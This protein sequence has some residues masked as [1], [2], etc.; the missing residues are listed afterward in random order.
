[1]AAQTGPMIN[2]MAYSARW[3]SASHLAIYAVGR[4][5]RAKQVAQEFTFLVRNKL[6]GSWIVIGYLGMTR[7]ASW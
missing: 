5:I 3:D 4:T 2:R 7:R 1:M 6:F